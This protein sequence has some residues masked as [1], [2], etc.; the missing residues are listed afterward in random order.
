MNIIRLGDSESVSPTPLAN[1]PPQAAFANFYYAA[2]NAA[3]TIASNAAFGTTMQF[4][5]GG[6]SLRITV[7]PSTF[8][9]RH[10]LPGTYVVTVAYRQNSGGDVWT[11][12]AVTKDGPSNA[13][14]ISERVASMNAILNTNHRVVYTVD[15]TTSTYQACTSRYS[16]VV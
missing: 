9:W 7:N 14:G 10:A 4:T 6:P 1:T 12:L 2:S 16:L 13:V 5:A 3:L 11:V 8:T 15:S